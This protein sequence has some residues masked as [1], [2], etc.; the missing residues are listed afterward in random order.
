MKLERPPGTV[1]VHP[2]PEHRADRR[3]FIRAIGGVTVGWPAA[4]AF[5]AEAHAAART[6]PTAIRAFAFDAYGTLFDV[7]SVTALCEDLFPGHG[8]GLAQLWRAKQLQYSMLR[9]LMDR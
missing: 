4:S 7:Y 2:A 9:T 8:D 5:D 1:I 3:Q 6:E